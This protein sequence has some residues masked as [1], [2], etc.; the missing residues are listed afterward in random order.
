MKI[1]IIKL[2]ELDDHSLESLAVSMMRWPNDYNKNEHE[3]MS[4]ELKNRM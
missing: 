4:Y 3:C 2:S 1:K